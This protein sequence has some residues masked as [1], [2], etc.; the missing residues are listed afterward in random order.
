MKSYPLV[1]ENFSATLF[2]RTLFNIDSFIPEPGTSIA[3]TGITGTGKSVLLNALAGLLP[4]N[5]FKLTGLMKLHGLDAYQAGVFTEFQEQRSPGHTVL[6][7][8]IFKKC[9]MESTKHRQEP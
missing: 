5:P 9:S 8:K 3:I 2:N 6:G 7:G 1:L 4:S